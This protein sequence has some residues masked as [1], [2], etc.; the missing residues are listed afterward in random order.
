MAAVW[1]PVSQPRCHLH[2]LGIMMKKHTI[3]IC[4]YTRQRCCLQPW[5][6]GRMHTRA[7]CSRCI[8]YTLF[9]QTCQQVT[10]CK[11]SFV[12]LDSCCRLLDK[13]VMVRKAAFS[14][15]DKLLSSADN[16]ATPASRQVLVAAV[17][18][19]LAHIF[20]ATADSPLASAG[21][22]NV[23]SNICLPAA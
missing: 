11:L 18:Q 21:N 10:A 6:G 1:L 5:R 7:L 12:S 17:I 13:S 23:R 3:M 9:W 16:N 4:M 8:A 19:D 20:S 14:A 15:M 22:H 2:H